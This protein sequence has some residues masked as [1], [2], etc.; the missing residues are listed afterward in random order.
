MKNSDAMRS[1]LGDAF[2]SLYTA[3]KDAEYSEFQKIITPYE[4]ETL[5]FNV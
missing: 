2:V 3:L 4:R 1:M 5:M